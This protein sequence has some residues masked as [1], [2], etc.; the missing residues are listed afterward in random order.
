MFKQSDYQFNWK[1]IGDIDLGRPNLG[2]LTNVSVYRLMQ[3]TMR[4]VL[5]KNYGVEKTNNLLFEAGWVAGSE[6]CKNVLNVNS[7][8]NDF[9]AELHD[10]LLKLKIGVLRV[11]RADIENLFFTLTVSEDLDCSGLPIT[12]ET[13]CDYDEGFIAGLL[14]VYLGKEFS[15]KE[16]DCW[17]TGDRTCRFEVKPK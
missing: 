17:S 4:A 7:D 15:V 16:I 11:E 13:V 12:D 3:Y 8:L 6:F 2:P 14:S 1:D 5:I 10:A 9:I